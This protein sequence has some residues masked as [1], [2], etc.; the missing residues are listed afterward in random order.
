MEIR[1]GLPEHRVPEAARDG[2]RDPNIRREGLVEEPRTLQP[3]DL[4]A[5]TRVDLAGPF[6]CEEGWQVEHLTWRGVR[7]SDVVALAGPRPEAF[8]IR[9]TSG[10]YAVLIA[11]T[12][13]DSALL[14]E[15]LNGEPLSLEHGGP[16]RLIVPGG[17]CFTSVKWVD[18]L[19]LTAEP[20]EESGEAIARARLRNRR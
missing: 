18:R 13:A 11:L 12:E 1:E 20:G 3:S 5:L 17:T 19:E 2:A 15:E 14:A 6:D 16:W 10:E 4:A 7:L 9:V 8:W